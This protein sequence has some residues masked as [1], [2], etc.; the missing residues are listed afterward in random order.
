MNYRYQWQHLSALLDEALELPPSERAAWLAALA[1]REPAV[2]EK[3]THL[4][5]SEDDNGDVLALAFERWL[6]P[7]LDEP[8]LATGP[9]LTGTHLGP[10]QLMEKIGEGGMGQVWRASRADGLY[11]GQAAIKLLRSDLPA[12]SLAGRFARERAALARLN[13]PA[14]ARLLDAGVSGRQAY[15]VLELVEGKSLTSFVRDRSPML[16]DRISLLLRVAEAV[17][18][19]HAHLIVHRDL[20]PSNVMVTTEGEPKLLDFGVAALLDDQ[21]E[22]TSDLT[23]LTGRGL[24]LGYAAPEQITG[25]AIGTAADVF[26]LGV[27]LYE[28]ISGGLPF[29]ERGAPRVLLEQ[30][31]LHDEP[32]RVASVAEDPQGAGR[33]Q[34]FALARG[35]LEAIAAKALRKDPGQRYGSVRAFMED[36][37]HWL[38]NRP[39]S[40]RRENWRHNIRLWFVRHVLLA[41]SVTLVTVSLSVGLGLS[42]WQW[43]QAQ[44]SARESREVTDYLRRLLASA[45]P[46]NHGGQWPTVLQLLDQSR[47]DIDQRFADAPDTRLQVL[48]VLAQT[49]RE[50]NRHDLAVPL[51]D[52]LVNMSAQRYGESD[53][54]TLEAR[55]EQALNLS[56]L[57]QCD[58]VVSSL[59][60]A[61]P[62]IRLAFRNDDDALLR[63]LFRLS[64]CYA[65]VG[66]LDDAERVQAE[67][68]GLIAK[69]PAA[70]FRH[71]SYLNHLQVVRHGQGR[72][73]EALEAMHKTRPYW[74]RT[75]PQYQRE[76][77]VL[78]RNTLVIQMRLAEYN[79]IEERTTALLQDIDLLLDK[80]SGLALSLRHELARYYLES[81]QWDMARRQREDN[82]AYAHASGVTHVSNELP[83]QMQ[84]FLVRALTH[85]FSPAELR[86]QAQALLAKTTAQQAQLGQQR[87]EIWL[88]VAR[89]AM[90][91]DDAELAGSALARFDADPSLRAANNPLLAS[92]RQRIEG[93]LA[94]LRGDLKTSQALLAQR[95]KSIDISSD[96]RVVPSWLAALDLA[97]TLVLQNDPRARAALADAATRRPGG[98]APGHPLDAVAQVL[99]ARLEA[100]TDNAPVVLGAL[101]VLSAAL[102][103]QGSRPLPGPGLASLHGAL[104]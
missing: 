88:A 1:A 43:R 5:P 80:G 15:L 92:R 38:A 101:T 83:S 11:Q 64:T 53:A 22:S 7:A 33:P 46:D 12:E 95:L 4:L 10:W 84:L 70:D 72:L 17:D 77:L 47:K 8:D 34:D 51:A 32:H 102:Q 86:R 19:A 82:L 36:L 2:A 40:V 29:S 37:G 18:Y 85:R 87:A 6:G 99:Q 96:R 60:P 21:S 89:A 16:S 62:R 56:L 97:Y 75:E 48:Q 9:N 3:L 104:F 39:V 28:L 90:A 55:L 50:L 35:D 23:R 79:G 25:S 65:H 44:Q 100:S 68:G 61:L 78:K 49:Y 69:L 13:H 24:T 67:A 52:E 73:H 98:V 81:G 93:Q 14:I 20:K 30:A 42:L 54:R 31:V 74:G 103:G 58:R 27:L 94:R 91:Y 59:E 66:R 57:G 26:S 45:S 71:A 41:T 76:I 63:A